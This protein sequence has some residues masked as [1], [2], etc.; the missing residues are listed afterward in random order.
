[1]T[2][3]DCYTSFQCLSYRLIHLF[4]RFELL[5]FKKLISFWDHYHLFFSFN[6]YYSTFYSKY[7]LTILCRIR[8]N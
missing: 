5:Q 6:T 1:M 4:Y 3:W 7:L 8:D 2:G